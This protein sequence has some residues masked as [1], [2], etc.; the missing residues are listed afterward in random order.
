M[1]KD[2]T[3]GETLILIDFDLT[4]YGYRWN[5][6]PNQADDSNDMT[7]LIFRGYDAAFILKQISGQAV[8]DGLTNDFMSDE[9]INE[10]LRI[11][12]ENLND[13]T[14]SH[15]E[16]LFEVNLMLPS[17]CLSKFFLVGNNE[18]LVTVYFAGSIIN[19]TILFFFFR[20]Y[21]E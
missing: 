7:H 3:T 2:D 6:I 14:V 13:D 9:D 1:D 5:H 21:Y 10:W 15:E 12:K 11:Y 4:A 17:V 19:S 8:R 16:L 20:K 18:I